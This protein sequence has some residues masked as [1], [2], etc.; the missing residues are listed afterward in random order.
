MTAVLKS[1]ERE[2]GRAGDARE[3]ARRPERRE[4]AAV[5][6]AVERARGVLVGER[7]A[8]DHARPVGDEAERLA[9]AQHE[10]VQAAAGER[11]V[12]RLEAERI[13]AEMLP[14][15]AISGLR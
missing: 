13:E 9:G 8:R 2:V 6:R 7:G 3:R 1:P 11:E 12:R 5:P 4:A 15:P 14:L 10:G